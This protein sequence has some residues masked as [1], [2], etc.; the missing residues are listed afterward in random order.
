MIVNK[1]NVYNSYYQLEN[2]EFDYF[3]VRG[4]IRIFLVI[5]DRNLVEG[6]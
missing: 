1:I 6:N 2:F 4:L 5:R 3:W